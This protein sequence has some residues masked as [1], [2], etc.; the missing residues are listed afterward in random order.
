VTDLESI[1]RQIVR[2]EL[3]KTKPANDEYLSTAEAARIASVTPGTVRRWI[4]QGELTR[5][6]AGAHVRVK[7]D[8][9]EALLRCDVV[10]I[11]K[12]LSLEERARRRFG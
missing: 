5:Y 10:S 9:L 4:R 2:D 8:E 1:V 12:N 6:E 3:A 11:D 7:R